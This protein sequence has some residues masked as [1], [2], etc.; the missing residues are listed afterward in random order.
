MAVTKNK[1]VIVGCGPGGPGYLTP[2]GR[3]AIEQ[4]QVLVGTPRLLKSFSTLNPIF[5]P[6]AAGTFSTAQRD[7][8]SKSSGIRAKEILASGQYL[9][10]IPVGADI[11]VAL[12]E[13]ERCRNLRVAVLVTGDPGLC[14]L[15]RPVRARFGRNHCR[16]IPGVSSVQAAFASVGLDWFDARIIS[17]HERM[18][19]MNTAEFKLAGK[20]AILA[21]GTAANEWLTSLARVMEKSHRIFLCSNLTLPNELVR[22]VTAARL[23]RTAIP[24][25]TVVLFIRKDL[26]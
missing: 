2:A 13:I 18:P 1:I 5:R 22:R 20:I 19:E 11:P 6:S 7:V 14:S 8:N 23:G 16:V 4:A 26:L 15:A 25:R 24:S 17:A 21:G 12:D 3:Q 10:V 9:H